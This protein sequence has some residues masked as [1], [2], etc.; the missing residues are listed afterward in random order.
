MHAS[1]HGEAFSAM[2][3]AVLKKHAIAEAATA[4]APTTLLSCSEKAHAAPKAAARPAAPVEMMQTEH[5]ANAQRVQVP[6]VGSS[7][8]AGTSAFG[9]FAKRCLAS[10]AYASG[11]SFGAHA[12]LRSLEPWKLS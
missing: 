2:N 1:D 6:P 7:S 4:T 9:E 11:A 12:Y 10:V 8:S 5:A 3:M